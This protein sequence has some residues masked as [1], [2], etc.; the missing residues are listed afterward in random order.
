[1]LLPVSMWEIR[2]SLRKILSDTRGKT[3]SSRDEV[4]GDNNAHAGQRVVEEKG[5]VRLEVLQQ[6]VEGTWGQESGSWHKVDPSQNRSV[7]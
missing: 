4:G 1:M 5:D 3:N 7:A 2:P 6:P